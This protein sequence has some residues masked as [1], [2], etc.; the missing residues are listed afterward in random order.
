[1]RFYRATAFLFPRSYERRVMFFCFAAVHVPLVACIA[2][3]AF[4]GEW[5]VTTL[6]TLLL[7]TLVGTGL[8]LAAIHALLAP[9]GEAT[10][11]LSAIQNG[12]RIV[13][14][15]QGGDD[16]VG[17]LLRGVTTTANETA[18]RMEQ[19]VD[20]A[21]RDLLTG[22]RNRRGFLDS[23]E[24]VLRS[25]SNAVLGIIDIDHFKLI[26][27]EFGHD[28]GDAILQALAQK[29]ENH[30]RRSD[31]AARWGGEEFA[32][33]LP[34]TT[35]EEARL[36][37]ERLRAAVALDTRLGIAGRAV[38]FSCGL[39]PVRTFAQLGDATRQADAA[40]YSAKNAGRN[41][42]HVRGL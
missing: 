2:F 23:A 24:Q 20:A 39:A 12:E 31:I 18:A 33:L 32:V 36:V 40:L 19:L 27:D 28:A 5:Q 42:V 15:P 10:A 35:L 4:T 34:R 30:L 8:G 37:M 1:M 7:A 41:R 3:Q 14:V 26:N 38:T 25:R 17:R 6:L 11:M 21:E 16:L 9:I 22:I 13:T 29:I